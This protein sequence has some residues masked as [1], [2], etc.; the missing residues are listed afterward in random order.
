MIESAGNGNLPDVETAANR[1]RERASAG[2]SGENHG[3]SK[4][5]H[6][7]EKRGALVAKQYETKEQPE[8]RDKNGA[9][10]S[11]AKRRG[12]ERQ[13]N[14]RAPAA[15]GLLVNRER[16]GKQSG[17]EGGDKIRIP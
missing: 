14:P 7:E 12:L 9:G 17:K 3:R 8:K 2:Q 16:Y 11:G 10:A 13:K 6:A 1:R 5:G 15:T 4:D